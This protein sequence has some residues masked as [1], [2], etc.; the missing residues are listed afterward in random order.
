MLTEL[1][2]SQHDHRNDREP[3][4]GTKVSTG[5]EGMRGRKART[6]EKSYRSKYESRRIFEQ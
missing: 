1:K 6:Y 2:N 5:C 3:E 4:S